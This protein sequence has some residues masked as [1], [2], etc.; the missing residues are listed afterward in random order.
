MSD[1]VR[2]GRQRSIVDAQ[3]FA[4]GY[5]QVYETCN[6]Q[7]QRRGAGEGQEQKGIA[8]LSCPGSRLFTLYL[9]LLAIRPVTGRVLQNGRT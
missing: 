2:M 8:S 1:S 6:G 7:L 9:P 5:R 4:A 3:V